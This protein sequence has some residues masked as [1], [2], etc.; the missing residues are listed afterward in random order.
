MEAASAVKYSDRSFINNLPNI[1]FLWYDELE[2][3]FLRETTF[4]V[5]WY[6]AEL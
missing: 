3:M 4:P 5:N 6:L 1:P 2:C